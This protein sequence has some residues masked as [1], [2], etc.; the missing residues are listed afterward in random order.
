MYELNV[1]KILLK[2]SGVAL[3]L[4]L[5]LIFPDLAVLNK[6]YTAETEMN[7]V[8]NCLPSQLGC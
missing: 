7:K 3:L 5:F 1:V 6:G 8:T 2:K 4:R